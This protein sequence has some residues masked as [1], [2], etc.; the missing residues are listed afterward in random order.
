[1]FLYQTRDAKHQVLFTF[2]EMG[3]ERGEAVIYIATEESQEQIRNEM[4]K[5]GLDV[6]VHEKTGA[7]Q[8]FEY[9]ASIYDLQTQY[10]AA[11]IINN[12]KQRYH[13]AIEQ[14]FQGCRITGE[15]TCFFQYDMIEE[16]IDYEHALHRI[17]DLPLIGVCA[18]NSQIMNRLSDP[19][20]VY[21]EL[22]KA[23]G[24][25]LFMKTNNL[26]GKIDIQHT[27]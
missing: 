20:Q 16:M 26:L 25:L 11:Q 12:L 6:D 10:D 8:L 7:L 2:L 13:D 23:H 4:T 9:D 5:W 15:M 1:M 3:L 24:S 19:L 18:F 27:G 22:L 21:N 17:L 14:G